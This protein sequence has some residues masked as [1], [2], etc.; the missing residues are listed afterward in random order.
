[1]M[2]RLYAVVG[3]IARERE[4][5]LLGLD[6]FSCHPFFQRGDNSVKKSFSY[7][8]TIGHQLENMLRKH[9]KVIMKIQIAA[10]KGYYVPY[11]SALQIYTCKS[12][13]A[14][15]TLGEESESD[16][17]SDDSENLVD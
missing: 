2:D 11:L 6:K 10:P 5:M 12:L 4:E 7:H 16:Y 13:A 15:R 9:Q 17:W 1:M 14:L 3:L 8:K